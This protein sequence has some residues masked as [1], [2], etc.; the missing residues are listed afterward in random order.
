MSSHE[1]ETPLAA[2]RDFLAQVG[3]GTVALLGAPA[4]LHAAPALTAPPLDEKWVDNLKGK[5]R[6]YFDA[7]EVN[8]GFAL[9]YAMNW[10]DSMKAAYGVTDKDLNAVVGFATFPFRLPT[11]TRSGRSTSW[12]NSQRSTTRRPTRRQ[13][14]TS[15]TTR[16]KGTS[17]SPR[18]R[19]KSSS[20]EA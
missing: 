10:M 14:G 13:R 18:W 9:A 5:Y 6:Q 11:R 8:S 19:W 2:R 16:R 15:T 1:S 12:V 20:R 17:C 7:T 4:L 3:A